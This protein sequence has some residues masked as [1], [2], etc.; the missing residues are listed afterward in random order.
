MVRRHARPGQQPVLAIDDLRVR[1]RRRRG[2]VTAVDGVTLEVH[3]GEIVGVIGESGSGKSMTAFSVMRLLPKT[4]DLSGS[5]RLDG[6]EL[7]A[8]PEAA[9]RDVRGNR[10]ALIPQDALQSLNPTLRVGFQVGEPI[11]LHRR[12]T[13]TGL[14]GRVLDLMRAVGMARPEQTVR[15]W[16]HQLSGGMQQRAMIAT[17]LALEPRL[18]IADEPTT[19]LDVTVQAGILDLLRAIRD[20]SGAGMMFIT[21]DL[22]MV[23][24]LCD[25]VYVMN[26]GR[27]VEHGPVEQVLTAPAEDYTRMLLAATPS[28][29]APL[30]EV[31]T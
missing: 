16:P 4:A 6:Q 29:D 25:Y 30:A 26:G 9:M 10:I 3:P 20:R 22:G 18:I 11:A 27:V 21:H 2:V 14:R 31:G 1:F 23:A 7:T 5:I 15:A 28:L 19:A 13:G 12:G 24:E 8:L 17:G